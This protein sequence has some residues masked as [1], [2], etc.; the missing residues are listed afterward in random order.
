MSI[1]TSDS[2][3]FCEKYVRYFII[4]P[5]AEIKLKDVFLSMFKFSRNKFSGDS[6]YKVGFF[7]F[8]VSYKL[9]LNK[10]ASS[11]S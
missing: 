4:L 11:S 6:M 1:C 3:F 7:A 9:K 8:N 2:E 5:C 10:F